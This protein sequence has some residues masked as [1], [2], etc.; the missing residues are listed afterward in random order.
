MNKFKIAVGT[1]SEQKIGYLKEVLAD[2]KVKAELIPVD[3]KSGVAEQPKTTQETERGSVNRAK[4]AFNLAKDAD[5]ALG[6][7]VGYHK[8]RKDSGY[9]MFCWV[10]I[11][12]KNGYQIS[13]QSHKFLLPKYF[14]ELL[15]KDVY[16]GYNLDGYLA[17]KERNGEFKEHVDFI[18][19]HRKPFIENA[20]KNALIRYLNKE[21]F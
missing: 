16:L 4:D 19:R 17:D 21:D 11:I 20:L 12:D 5:F 6:I 10:T 18:V 8:E 14:Q 3:V 9:E 1:T 13:S 15:D 7:E 2:L